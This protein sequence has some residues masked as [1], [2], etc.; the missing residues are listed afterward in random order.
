MPELFYAWARLIFEQRKAFLLE[1]LEEDRGLSG[2]LGE[3]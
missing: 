1:H 3:K 2:E